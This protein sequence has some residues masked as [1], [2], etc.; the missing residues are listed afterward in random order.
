MRTIQ[1]HF[2]AFVGGMAALLHDT[3]KFLV[4][5]AARFA[6]GKTEKLK[7]AEHSNVNLPFL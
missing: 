4:M 6:A 7:T 5:A 1:G 2:R 3:T